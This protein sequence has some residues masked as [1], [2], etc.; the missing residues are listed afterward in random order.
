VTP[1]ISREFQLHRANFHVTHEVREDTD[2][3]HDSEEDGYA[4][5]YFLHWTNLALCFL[6][7]S[8]F[9]FLPIESEI[10]I[11]EHTAKY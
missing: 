8:S 3:G 1:L 10:G 5:D 11:Q 9:W 7:F 6:D 2:C 4:R